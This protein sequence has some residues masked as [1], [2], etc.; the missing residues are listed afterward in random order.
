MAKLFCSRVSHSPSYKEDIVTEI[1]ERVFE[2][3][4][5]QIADRMLEGILFEVKFDDSGVVDVSIRNNRLK[6]YFED[7]FNSKRFYHDVKAVAQDIL[8]SGDEVE[9]PTW[10]KDK[11][12]KNGINVA[13]ITP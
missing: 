11:Y 7:N 8:D 13:Y 12:Y 5:Y 4:G 1:P 3:D 2:I 10:L 6:S 9:I